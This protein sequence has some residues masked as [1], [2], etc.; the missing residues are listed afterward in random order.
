MQKDCLPWPEKISSW[1]RIILVVSPGKENKRKPVTETHGRG[2]PFYSGFHLA[3]ASP[4]P[5]GFVRSILRDFPHRARLRPSRLP[6]QDRTWGRFSR[7]RLSWIWSTE[8]TC[9]TRAERMPFSLQEP[10]ARMETYLVLGTLP[11]LCLSESFFVLPAC[12]NSLLDRANRDI[13]YLPK[14]L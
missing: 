6:I 5:P 11:G 9:L 1:S 3:D 2:F 13:I 10:P 8:K 7:S 4:G 12:L 14:F